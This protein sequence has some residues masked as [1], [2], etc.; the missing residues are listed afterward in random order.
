MASSAF[1]VVGL[2]LGAQ[3]TM[4]VSD[5]GEII[6]TSTGKDQYIIPSYDNID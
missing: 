1:T 5:D 6:R 3:K 2:D 4:I